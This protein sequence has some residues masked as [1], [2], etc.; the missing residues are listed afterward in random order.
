MSLIRDIW[1]ILTASQRR[2]VIAT[3]AVS[4]LM[5][6]STLVGIASIA[7]FFAVLGEPHLIGEQPLLHWL[8]IRGGFH[9]VRAFEF[10]LG[11]GFV[12]L[13]LAANLMNAVGLLLLRRLALGIGNELQAA[14]FEE[15]LDR[16]YLFHCGTNSA[17]LLHNV[18]YE[19]GRLNNGILQNGFI[20]V[21]QLVTGSLIVLSVM[22]LDPELALAMILALAG[23]YLIIYLGVRARLLRLGEEHARAWSER[24][25]MAGESFSAIREILLLDDRKVFLEGFARASER[26]ARTTAHVQ[27]VALLPKNI[28]EGFGAVALVVAALV[29]SGRGGGMGASLGELT[30]VAFAAYRLLPILQQIFS[31]CVEIRADSPGF[32]LIAPDL[33]AVRAANTRLRHSAT[34]VA[35]E[36]RG[37]PQAEILLDGVSFRYS[38]GGPQVLADITARIPARSTVGITGANGSG[39]TTLMDIIAGL[40]VPSEGAIW[41]DGT[42][43]DETNRRSWRAAIA[44]VPQ[45]LVLLD[46]SIAEN[47]AFGEPPSR[48]DRRRVAEAARAAQLE[49]LV[50]N[51]PEGYQHR[52]GERGIR[53]SGGQRQ[54]VGIARALYRRASVLMLDEATSALDGMTEAELL[55]TLA[56]L[57][58]NCTILLIA[59]QSG[60]LRACDEILHLHAGRL[61]EVK[62]GDRAHHRAGM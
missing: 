17:T 44:Y 27:V 45:T 15:Y 11:S 13:V 53:L 1:G 33:R 50:A 14:L 60:T 38:S 47:I 2:R 46:A 3:Q 25:R 8:Y 22:L 16:P 18:V 51:L 41:V 28:M 58:G 61:S 12:A 39:K 32:E 21:T 34:R 23:G 42:R 49:E 31:C 26:A 9:G 59:H 19:I 29:F 56:R 6:F 43:L 24:S 36:W 57:R 5:A 30:F 55:L 20:L 7:P 10:A 62:S 48:I 52:V 40:L 4:V 35:G 37:R 54:R